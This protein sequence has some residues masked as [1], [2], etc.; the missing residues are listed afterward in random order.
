MRPLAERFSLAF[1]VPGQKSLSASRAISYQA[2]PQLYGTSYF[3]ARITPLGQSTPKPSPAQKVPKVVSIRPTTNLRVFSGTL[4]RGPRTRAPASITSRPAHAAPSA[5][6]AMPLDFAA[7][8]A[9]LLIAPLL[10]AALLPNVI[11]IK[12]TSNPSNRTAL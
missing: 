9:S 11:T 1:L 2:Q 10:A 12:A 8:M 4:V 7:I 3:F 6:E 5:A